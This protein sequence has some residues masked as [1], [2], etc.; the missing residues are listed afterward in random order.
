MKRR[1]DPLHKRGTAFSAA[2]ALLVLLILSLVAP[3]SARPQVKHQLTVEQALTLA[4]EKS[5]A[6]SSVKARYV[7]AKKNAE[8]ALRTLWTS[9]SLSLTAP[10]YSQS[11]SQQFNPLTGVYDYYQLRSNSINSYLTVSQPIHLTGGT[12]S[13][14][15]GLLGR[16]QTS[17][18]TDLTTQTRDFFSNF[19]V[20]FQ[21][22]LFTPNLQAISD[23][24]NMLALE[25]AESD[26]LQD[27]LDLVYNVTA[28]FFS[29]YQLSRHLEIVRE[30]VRQNEES[31]TTARNKAEA[32][33]IPEVEALQSEVDLASSRNDVLGAEREVAQAKNAFRLLVG[34]ATEDDVETTGE[35]LYHP[36]A[37]D[38]DKAIA[39]ALKYRPD[40]L[41]A[42]RGISLAEA[43]VGSAQA[44]NGFRVDLTAR[45]G[46]NKRDTLFSNLFQDFDRSKGFSLTFSVP[47]FDWGSH[48]LS[49]QA[50]EVQYQNAIE[51]AGYRRQQVKQEI[52]DLINGIRVA[53]SRLKVLEKASGV[54]EKSYGISLERFRTGTI[55]RNDLALAQQRLTTART[56]RLNA[57]VDYEL[58]LADLRRRTLWDFESDQPVKPILPEGE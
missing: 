26:Y 24:R 27:Q 39:S 52:L 44:A 19:A 48:H 29:L 16:D 49:V 21:Q 3:H 43:N 7:A 37:I 36:V 23:T 2:P 55:T 17:G 50:A 14:T 33:L 12:L 58:G 56:N 15:Q 10:S 8:S 34:I 51:E 11:L 25:Q 4:I 57:L 9:V 46:L 6:A 40:V 54:A 22:P 5:F 38:S 20:E 1:R 30:Q 41:A 28:A 35:V 47:L 53:E 45:Y 31:Y 13:F 42:E 32:G 18:L